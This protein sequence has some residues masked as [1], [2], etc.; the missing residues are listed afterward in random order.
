MIL[1]TATLNRLLLITLCCVIIALPTAATASTTAIVTGHGVDRAAALHDAMRN[2]IEQ[3]IGILLDSQTIVE[4]YQTISDTIYSHSEGYVTDYTILNETTEQGLYSLTAQI[5]I[6]ASLDST[7][8][9]RFQKVKAIETGLEDPRLGILIADRYGDDYPIA[10]NAIINILQNNGFSRI[11][12]LQQIE[13]SKKQQ[14]ASAIFQ[15]QTAVIHALK[16]QFPVD[17]LLVGNIGVLSAQRPGSHGFK[18][19]MSGQASLNL[20]LYNMNTGEIVY[21]DTIN[22]TALHTNGDMAMS[23]ALQAAAKNA[24][25][26]LVQA[27]MKKATNPSH[28][29]QLIVTNGKLGTIQQVQEQLKSITGVSQVYLRSNSFDTMIFDL[30]YYGSALSFANSLQ[31]NGIS[32]QEISTEFVKI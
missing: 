19:F 9:D 26:A 28:H 11:V 8:M 30:N 5:S 10:G 6:S 7:I 13:L 29:L 4:N 21:A 24:E 3:K 17:Y 12:D 1:K 23:N 16:T 25:P 31:S 15:N 2:A 14:I 18:Q 22:A 32:V 27:L 20:R